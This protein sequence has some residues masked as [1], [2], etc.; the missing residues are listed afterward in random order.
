MDLLTRLDL[1]PMVATELMDYR[2]LTATATSGDVTYLEDR[3]NIHQNS[4]HQIGSFVVFG[5]GPNRGQV[6]RVADNNRSAGKLF[7]APT[8]TDPVTAGTEVHQVNLRGAGFVPAE[9]YDNLNIALRF[10]YPEHKHKFTIEVSRFYSH[11]PYVDLSLDPL[12]EGV[13]ALEF[14]SSSHGWEQAPL[15]AV[16]GADGYWV[17]PY[18]GRLYVGGDWPGMLDGL[19]IRIVAYRPPK[20]L[21]DDDA[22]CEVLPEWLVLDTCYRLLRAGVMRDPQRFTIAQSIEQRR[23][24]L[25]AA[26]RTPVT[27]GQATVRLN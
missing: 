17:S 2:K 20:L 4:D 16:E 24:R 15:S 12:I 26:I 18:D 22:I 7:L 25:A 6:C 11:T 10:A 9:I 13:D 27:S 19:D 23:E 1:L 21:L 14:Y 8:P 5:D 3:L